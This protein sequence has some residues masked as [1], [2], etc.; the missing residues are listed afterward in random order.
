[1]NVLKDQNKLLMKLWFTTK[2]FTRLNLRCFWG[3]IQFYGE[4]LRFLGERK[5]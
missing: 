4:H 3:K 5:Y 2:Q 1:M